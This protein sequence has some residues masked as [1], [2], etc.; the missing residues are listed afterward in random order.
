M[1]KKLDVKREELIVTVKIYY[2]PD[3]N[4]KMAHNSL[5]LS[6][7]HIIEGCKGSLKRL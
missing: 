7:K 2:G 4:E 1:I 5:G 6:R 3:R